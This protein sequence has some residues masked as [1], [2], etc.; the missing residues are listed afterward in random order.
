[1]S[2]SSTIRTTI[3]LVVFFFFSFFFLGM[4]VVERKEI[5]RLC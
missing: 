4:C 3:S 1:M 2:F 5:K